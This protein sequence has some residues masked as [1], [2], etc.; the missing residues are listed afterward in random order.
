MGVATDNGVCRVLGGRPNVLT[1]V[2]AINRQGS[3]VNLPPSV[4]VPS[5]ADVVN[6]CRPVI[7]LSL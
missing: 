2:T 3:A 1:L 5:L 4:I 6:V 7:P